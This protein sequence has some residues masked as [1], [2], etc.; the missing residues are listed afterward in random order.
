MRMEGVVREGVCMDM[1]RCVW[2]LGGGC[3]CDKRVCDVGG[4]GRWAQV[5]EDRG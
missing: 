3:G 5:K 4:C 2:V 1:R